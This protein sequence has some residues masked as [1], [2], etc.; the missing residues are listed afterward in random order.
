MPVLVAEIYLSN[1]T[2]ADTLEKLLLTNKLPPASFRQAGEKEIE[3]EIKQ[4]D[5]RFKNL[6][7]T[8]K[9][10]AMNQA[11]TEGT[12]TPVDVSSMTDP[13]AL[14]KK[15]VGYSEAMGEKNDGGQSDGH[16]GG[17]LRDGP[18]PVNAE[19]GRGDSQG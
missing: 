10:D 2:Q 17:T 19:A 16:A 9:L 11:V 18:T 14:T 3:K 4:V 12:Y 1:A 5:A 15:K 8:T 7:L 13:V 6:A